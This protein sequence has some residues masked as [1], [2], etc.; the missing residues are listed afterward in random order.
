MK[1]F[2][3]GLIIAACSLIPVVAFASIPDS[4]G[5]IHGCRL[6]LTG[7]V[8]IID[9]PSQSCTILETPIS[10]PSSLPT[11]IAPPSIVYGSNEFSGSGPSISTCPAGSKAIGASF[12][13]TISHGFAYLR[14][15]QVWGIGDQWRIYLDNMGTDPLYSFQAICLVP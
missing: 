15:S 14:E 9:S 10:W 2:I 1:K 11:P 3:V 13:N 6:N 5:T 4:N 8:R 12:A 7:I